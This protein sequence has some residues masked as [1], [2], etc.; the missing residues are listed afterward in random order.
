MSERSKETV[1]K[2]VVAQVTAGSNPALSAHI[3]RIIYTSD[4]GFSVTAYQVA[5]TA[6]KSR[7]FG[8]ERDGIRGLVR[9]RVS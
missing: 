8:F 2:T 7:L 4:S 5:S 6:R 1:L 9:L 3:P